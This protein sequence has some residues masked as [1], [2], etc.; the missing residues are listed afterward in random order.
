MNVDRAR[1]LLLTTALSAA[2][3][4]AASASGCSVTST[5][6]G[7]G[8]TT[9]VDSGYGVDGSDT[10]AYTTDASTEDGGACLDDTGAAADCTGVN[11]TC[12][13]ICQNIATNYKKGVARSIAGCLLKLPTCESAA[14]EIA[15]C[16]QA[17]LAAACTD[18]TA[19]GYCDPLV[20]VCDADGGD[21]GANAL[22]K[23][24]CTD[25]A[26]GLNT[27]G[28]TAFT[29]CVQGGQGAAYCIATPS[30]CIDTIER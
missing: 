22:D 18:P 14:M 29:S 15:T 12:T 19:E 27:A 17:G 7:P 24:E 28:R 25:L 8:T 10:D 11:A 9:P 23:V 3:A 30:T 2:T 21:G 16:V 20:N 26:T 13:T 5:N 6:N 1:F 4:V